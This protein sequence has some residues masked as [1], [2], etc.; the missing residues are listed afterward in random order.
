MNRL[1]AGAVLALGALL[2]VA[3]TAQGR[4]ALGMRASGAIYGSRVAAPSQ[5]A[6]S[7]SGAQT[8]ALGGYHTCA[9][10]E[11]GEILCWGYNIHGQ[12]GDGETISDRA[13][14][15]RVVQLRDV[16]AAASGWFH[17]CAITQTGGVQ[18]WG[19]NLDGQLG[20]GGRISSNA[21]VAVLGLDG[22]V[23]ALA[24]GAYHTCALMEDGAIKCWGANS[25]G[26]LGNATTDS[27]DRPVEVSQLRQPAQ[28]ISSGE[29]HTC[30]V[31]Q[32]GEVW[33][34]GSN[35][36]GQLGSD[37]EESLTPIKVVGLSGAARAISAGAR[38]TCA[39]L[40]RGAVQ[41]WGN[42]ANGQLGNGET[43]SS[44]RPVTVQGLSN[45]RA[46]AA[47]GY[48]TCALTAN[49]DVR[50]WGANN[51]GQIGD[52]TT[53]D[54]TVPVVVQDVS[55]ARA[56][57]AGLYHTCAVAQRG[58]I[59]CWGL[60]DT[61]QL[62]NGEAAKA[63]D[64]V[65]V[66]GLT[67]AARALAAGS[68]HTC[69]LAADGGMRCWGANLF[70]QLGDGSQQNRATPVAVSGLSGRARAIVAGDNHTCALMEGGDVLCWGQNQ[71]GQLGN[72][73][74]DSARTPE[75][76]LNLSRDVQSL[77]AGGQHTCALTAAGGV[78]C[79]GSNRYGQLGDG[80]TTDRLVPSSV[81]GLTGS[82]RAVAAGASH[83]CALVTNGVRCWGSNI[84]A[85]LGN[86]H[87]DGFS[88]TPVDVIGLGADVQALSAGDGYT[89]ALL[90]GGS[91]R[92]WGLNEFGQLGDGTLLMRLAPVQVRRL[93][94]SAQAVSAS[95]ARHACAVVSG[96]VAC[97]GSNNEG[98]LGVR[99]VA[100]S[101]TPVLIAGLSNVQS[102]AVGQYHT[103]ALTR[104][105]GVQCWGLNG[106]GQVG[107]GAP[108][109]RAQPVSVIR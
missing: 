109:Y 26:Q 81:P 103:C 3:P 4:L 76:V 86:G 18:C 31:V 64:P 79:W 61:G 69:A 35:D 48:H 5:Q 94:G 43:E 65:N 15:G 34:W 51:L 67:S 73:S 106:S 95:G 6:A 84:F 45:A 47:G 41:C 7:L 93:S 78:L 74:T 100:Q 55:N 28:A 53:D 97:W 1:G 50:C 27:S 62:G 20:N 102:V 25:S 107:N 8:L 80:T 42:N 46:I 71:S 16:R 2:L 77:A 63:L 49:N 59:R 82:V 99:R 66:S 98:Q 11:A 23:R 44:S 60:N 13:R 75:R 12:L 10:M 87:T 40:D 39:L 17:T 58:E 33:C 70:G 54:R 68:E 56:I 72:N 22:G 19:N 104:T 38:H 37:G 14:P 96:G 85:Q 24:A 88:P 91:L 105:G 89:C 36:A 90:R 30:A 101:S 83:T 32:G 108:G 29:L 57:G 92:C 52:R 21:P 9:L